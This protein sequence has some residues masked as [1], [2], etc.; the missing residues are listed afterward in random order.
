MH[1]NYIQ[2]LSFAVC[3]FIISAYLIVSRRPK[4]RVPHIPLGLVV[5]YFLFKIFVPIFNAADIKGTASSFETAAAIVL[6]M[7]V[8]RIIVYLIVDYFLRKRRELAIPTITRD[9]GLA[10]AYIVIVMIVLKQRTDVNLGSLLTT[11]AILTAV[12]GFAMQD[13]LGNLFSGLALQIEHPYQMDDWIGFEGI[14]GKVIGITWKS[15]KLLTR[16]EELIFVP[17]N[18]IAKSV[19]TNFSRPTP[20]HVTS[21]EVGTSYNDPPHKV[22]K[23]ITETILN[24]PRVTKSHPPLVAMTKYDNFSINYKAFF[25]TED[26]ATEGKTRFEIL[27]DLWYKF[28]RDGI[29]IPYPMQEQMDISPAEV[30]EN[31]KAARASDEREIFDTLGRIDIFTS[32]ADSGKRDLAGRIAVLPFAAG[33]NIV[34]Q[35]AEPGPMYVIKEGTCAVFVAHDGG[36]LTEV[37]RMG[38]MQFFG[39]MSVLTGAPRTATVKALTE[40]VCYEIEKEDLRALITS[41]QDVLLSISGVLAKRQASLDKQKAKIEDAARIATEQQNQ[42]MSKIKSFFGL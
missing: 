1:I 2:V 39:E 37:A 14:E 25:A 42:L 34:L 29:K 36:A 33:E 13:T 24:H 21:L 18:V 32:L 11:S 3:A 17:N 31:A 28:R 26:F 10:I 41:N 22:R 7:A 4:S 23:A 19:L 6:W 16:T 38:P 30:K 9:F 8:I 12:I 27:N 40:V 15:T 20:K 35:G 5:L